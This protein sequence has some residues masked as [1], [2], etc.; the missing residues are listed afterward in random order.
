MPAQVPSDA[1][2]TTEHEMSII[3]PAL[4]EEANIERAMT[5]ATKIAERLCAKHEIIVVDDGSTDRTAEIV[6]AAGVA[7][8]RI[9][10]VS[11]ER[12]Q[13]YGHA[14]R[15]GFAA[16]ELDLVFFT[17]AD[18]QFDL[19]E[20]ELFLPSI[21]H[22]DVV[23]GFRYNRQDPFMRRVFAKGWN[24]II[25]VLFYAPVRDI[26]CAFKLFRRSVF[27]DIRLEA[28]GAMVSTEL[29]VRIARSG[30]SVIEIGVTH[31]PRTAGKARGAD[32]RV[33]LK[34]LRELRSMY[35]RLRAAGYRDTRTL[36][37]SG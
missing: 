30:K 24:A 27:E 6:R 23:V 12:N 8:P 35:V 1:L 10:L 21:E 4:N 28:M 34:A 36:R 29:M 31:Y 32:P 25:R 14:L 16:A 9:R 5:A 22:A 11:H 26:D 13:G 17:D 2:A 15:S 33:I 19:E 20:L 37:Q 18:N 3:L 7:D